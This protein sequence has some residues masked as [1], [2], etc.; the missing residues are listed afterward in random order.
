M[1]T[2][3]RLFTF[4]ALDHQAAQEHLNR[5]CGKGWAFTGLTLGFLARYERTEP[6]AYRYFVDWCDLYNED[7]GYLG[8]CAD[9][10]WEEVCT[11]SYLRF[12]RSRPGEHPSPIHTDSGLEYQRF[13]RKVLRRM[14][15]GAAS[16]LLAIGYLFLIFSLFHSSVSTVLFRL[17]YSGFLPTALTV[18]LPLLAAGGLIYSAVM[19]YK[20]LRWRSA[21]K[22][23]SPFPPANPIAVKLRCILSLLGTALIALMLLCWIA[24]IL[25]K[26]VTGFLPVLIGGTI[27]LALSMGLRKKITERTRKRGWITLGVIW[28]VVLS[29]VAL[30]HLCPGLL[31]PLLPPGSQPPLVAEHEFR[32]DY[33]IDHAGP[34]VR[35]ESW[36]ENTLDRPATLRLM[37]ERYT[38]RGDTLMASALEVLWSNNSWLTVPI[39]E[40]AFERDG[41]WEI[42]DE[43]GETFLLLRKE[44]SIL[45]I[46]PTGQPPADL[47]DTAWA[48]LTEEA[49]T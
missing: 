17:L 48:F 47:A 12:F 21:A 23:N 6:D 11:K 1:R 33:Y 5:M 10:G 46:I 19:C 22:S 38:L 31:T 44:H 25:L 8:L 7:E 40:E 9:A 49:T 15:F 2:K 30:H 29:C 13:Y 45:L 37:C 43:Y 24:D 35:Y 41:V 36:T 18:I 34:L 27:G 14:A 20:L 16:C 26:S 32:D 3:R 4:W 42:T 39:P 28:A